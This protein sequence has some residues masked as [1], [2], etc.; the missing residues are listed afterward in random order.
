[1]RNFAHELSQ[2][3]V[4][5]DMTRYIPLASAAALMVAL[6]GCGAE[7]AQKSDTAP[8][9][10]EV[11]AGEAPAMV[12]TTPAA[13]ETPT[14]PEAAPTEAARPAEN[15]KLAAKP[16]VPPRA[17]AAPEAPKPVETEPDPHAGHDMDKK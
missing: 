3:Q 14:A 10:S 11:P 4:E 8:E 6:A 13:D 15:S 5:I 9:Q 12:E 17:K 7:S 16:A 2:R 1:L